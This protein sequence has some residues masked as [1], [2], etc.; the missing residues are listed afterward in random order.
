MPIANPYPC[1]KS[2][3]KVVIFDF[4]GTLADTLDPILR[5]SNRLAP[6]FGYQAVSA[7]EIEQLRNL[8]FREVVKHSEISIFKIP[9]LLRRLR[10]DLNKEIDQVKPISGIPEVLATLKNQEILLGILT[11]NSKENVTGFLQNNGLEDLF[12]F[13]YSG[14]TILGKH[15][16]IKRVLKQGQFDPQRVTYVGD[17]TRDIESA[18]KSQIK[19]IAVS[20]GFSS[21]QA[22]AQ[23]S[24]DFLVHQPRELIDVIQ[25]L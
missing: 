1:D 15:K 23:Q 19:V 6:E 11:S 2:L 20:W 8:T 4:D 22:L 17:E 18:R 12:S 21:S 13:I 14:T 24:P 7:A 10:A 16:M 3:V 9:L 5:I 25:K